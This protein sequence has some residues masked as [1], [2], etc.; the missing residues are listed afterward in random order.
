MVC[1]LALF[2]LHLSLTINLRSSTENVLKNA[3]IPAVH[4][5]KFYLV[6][7]RRDSISRFLYH[8]APIQVTVVRPTHPDS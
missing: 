4:M 8:V 1:E 6:T 5:G 3:D 2:S 7:A